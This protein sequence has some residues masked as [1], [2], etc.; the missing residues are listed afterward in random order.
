MTTAN[1]TP[2][3]CSEWRVWTG[4]EVEGATDVGVDTLFV[5]ETSNLEELLIKHKPRR[6]WLCKEYLAACKGDAV[7]EETLAQC[8][9][10]LHLLGGLIVCVEVTY[11]SAFY[12]KKL[13]KFSNVRFYVKL[14]GLSFLKA[15]DHVCVGAAFNDEIFPI[16]T[17]QRMDA[18]AYLKDVP[19]E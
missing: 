19:L 6:V 11:F 9:A 18:S 7:R 12:W 14:P 2:P 1:S 10:A 3:P 16:G 15:G 8:I 13:S 17:G 4:P 5:R